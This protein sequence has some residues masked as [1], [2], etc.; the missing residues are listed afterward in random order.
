MSMLSG[1]LRPSRM[2]EVVDIG[3]NPIDGDP[4]YKS[5]LKEGLCRVTGVSA[6]IKAPL[7][8]GV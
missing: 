4:P 5:M 8:D 7:F 6:N 1:L 3:A 2:T